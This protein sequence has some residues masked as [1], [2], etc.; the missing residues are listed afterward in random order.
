MSAQIG[1]ATQ[2]LGLDKRYRPVYRRFCSERA[3]GRQMTREE[4][5]AFAVLSHAAWS[6]EGMR[7]LRNLAKDPSGCVRQ[8]VAIQYSVYV[9]AP[10]AED[11]AILSS[12]L[13]EPD[14]STQ[15]TALRALLR[16]LPDDG[17]RKDFAREYLRSPTRVGEAGAA[18]AR[19]VISGELS[20]SSFRF[21]GSPPDTEV[22]TVGYVDL[23]SP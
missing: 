21:V 11:R 3:P 14:E 10:T 1:A 17:S 12:L 4:R 18:I 5:V 22:L 15:V 16:A 2:K 23:R 9:A 6:P 8:A 13:R 20:G 19:R 7:H